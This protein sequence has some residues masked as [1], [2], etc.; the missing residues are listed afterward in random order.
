MRG[1]RARWNDLSENVVIAIGL[2]GGVAAM[3]GIT[4]LF[5]WRIRRL[6][7]DTG[8]VEDY[9]RRSGEPLTVEQAATLLAQYTFFISEWDKTQPN[10]WE[11]QDAINHF[12]GARSPDSWP[13]V[14]LPERH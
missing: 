13:R 9:A 5:E 7:R 1:A 4:Q 3:E 12:F 8:E 2:V 14:D 6:E 11:L 10:G